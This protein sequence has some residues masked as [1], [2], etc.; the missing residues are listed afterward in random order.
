MDGKL[1]EFATVTGCADAD[2]A[3]FFLESAAGD[4]AAAVEAKASAATA[5]ARAEFE[6][7]RYATLSESAETLRR[8]LRELLDKNAGAAKRVAASA[9]KREVASTVA[10]QRSSLRHTWKPIFTRAPV[11]K[12]TRPSREATCCRAPTRRASDSSS[13]AASSASA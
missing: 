12:K 2:K 7:S 5:S 1:A 13:L 4:V 6:A 8:D 3:R 9:G 11:T 10:P